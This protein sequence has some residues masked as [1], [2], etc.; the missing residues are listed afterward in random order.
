MSQHELLHG[1]NLVI[2]VDGE[3]M[4]LSK[5]CT[6]DVQCDT[7]PVSGPTTGQWED[8]IPGRKK[9]EVTCNHLMY[10]R[11]ATKPFDRMDLV[12]QTVSL[13]MDI[14]YKDNVVA[15]KGFVENVTLDLTPKVVYIFQY[16][17]VRYDTVHKLFV[18]KD[19]NTYYKNWT[20]HN[21]VNP[22][23]YTNVNDDTIYQDYTNGRAAH[24]YYKAIDDYEQENFEL[25]RRDTTRQ[26][27]A[28][29]R[30]WSGTF[31]WG[32]LAQGSFKFLGKGP[33]SPLPNTEEE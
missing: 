5:S 30:T 17:D 24:E 29:I 7:I 11:G 15:F 20:Y 33:L 19:G 1:R 8:N 13:A 14:V 28:I 3:L 18:L 32:N 27:Q 31:T 4:A 6:V 16:A 22:Y 10:N 9:W 12:G 2:K 21:R 23:D 26:G 25:V